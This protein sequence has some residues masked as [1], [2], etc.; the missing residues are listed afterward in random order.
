MPLQPGH[1]KLQGVARRLVISR[2]AG[3][4]T[5]ENV[6]VVVDRQGPLVHVLSPDF[7]RHLMTVLGPVQV[8]WEDVAE[9][10]SPRR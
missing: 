8:E 7:E 9:F 5:F 10:Q 6:G 1:F 3:E 2:G 4:R